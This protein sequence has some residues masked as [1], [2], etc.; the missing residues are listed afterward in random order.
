MATVLRHRYTP[1]LPCTL[2]CI[3]RES[4]H[5][6]LNFITVKG[7]DDGFSLLGK[8]YH[9]IGKITSMHVYP[10]ATCDNDESIHDTGYVLQFCLP[11]QLTTAACYLQ[12]DM[13]A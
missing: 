7:T 12:I 5:G 6:I 1:K 3:V 9:S 11:L 8:S 10:H 2:Y 4:K 13:F